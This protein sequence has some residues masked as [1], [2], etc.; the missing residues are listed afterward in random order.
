MKEKDFES[1]EMYKDY[2]EKFEQIVKEAMN[3][4]N[5]SE[6]LKDNMHLFDKLDSDMG[7]IFKDDEN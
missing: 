7:D 3:S 1:P 5:W 6:D 2:F 4:G